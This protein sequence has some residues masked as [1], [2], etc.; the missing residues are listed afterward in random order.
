MTEPNAGEAH[1]IQ[2]VSESQRVDAGYASG[3]GIYGKGRVVGYAE[4]PTLIIE[5][6]DGTRFSWVADLCRPVDITTEEMLAG[7]R[8]SLIRHEKDE[9]AFSDRMAIRALRA[10]IAELEERQNGE[11]A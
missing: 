7:L 11:P 2:W 1:Y 5:A 8:I 9:R 10:V 3:G 6:D 4:Q